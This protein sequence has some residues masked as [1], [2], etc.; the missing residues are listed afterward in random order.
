MIIHTRIGI[1]L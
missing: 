1:W